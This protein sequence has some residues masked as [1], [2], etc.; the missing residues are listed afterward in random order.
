M[1]ALTCV[2]KSVSKRSDKFYFLIPHVTIRRE[3]PDVAPRVAAKSKAAA[4]VSSQ[5]V[6]G[7]APTGEANTSGA[8]RRKPSIQL[9]TLGRKHSRD[10]HM[11]RLV[12]GGLS[13][14][15]RRA[16][17][18]SSRCGAGSQ[19]KVR[20]GLALF[21]A[22]AEGRPG[23]ALSDPCFSRV[24]PRVFRRTGRHALSWAGRAG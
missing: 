15:P 21:S 23:G 5:Q 16:S 1:R 19:P 10:I 8:R 6:G 12:G 14:G 4:L 7:K 2:R 18:G 11:P 24:P 13:P 22:S 3:A 20:P 9:Q 17:A